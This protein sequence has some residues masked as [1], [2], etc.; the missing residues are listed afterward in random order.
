MTSIQAGSK[1]SELLQEMPLHAATA[2]LQ[3]ATALLEERSISESLQF[4]SDLRSSLEESPV[5]P[6]M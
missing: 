3:I 1:I 2:A 4:Y 5:S 6:S